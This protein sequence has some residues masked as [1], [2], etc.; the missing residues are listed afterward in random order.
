ML[1]SRAVGISAILR[2]GAIECLR[3][4]KRKRHHGWQEQIRF[5]KDSYGE[6]NFTQRFNFTT[7][8]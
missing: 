7:G 2:W 1:P 6:T 3:E 8:R 4:A 5:F